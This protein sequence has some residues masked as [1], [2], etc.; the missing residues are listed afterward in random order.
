M[1]YETEPLRTDSQTDSVFI[2]YSIAFLEIVLRNLYK[3]LSKNFLCTFF[4][5]S[6]GETRL[7]PLSERH[8]S[9]K[10]SRVSSP[11]RY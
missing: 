11:G 5:A 1:K 9:G 8:H 3:Y 4:S 2:G 10:K 6:G 7:F